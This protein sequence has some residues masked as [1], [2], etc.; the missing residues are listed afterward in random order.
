MRLRR[1]LDESLEQ[2][3]GVVRA[4]SSVVGDDILRVENAD[5]I[6]AE[7]VHEQKERYLAAYLGGA[8][9]SPTL[10]PCITRIIGRRCRIARLRRRASWYDDIEDGPPCRP[11]GDDHPSVWV[12]DGRAVAYVSQPYHL[13]H[14]SLADIVSFCRQWGLRADI[15]ASPSPH[16]PGQ[17]ITIVYQRADGS[18]GPASFRPRP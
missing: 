6:Y 3:R 14:E 13:H 4:L 12:R 17:T 7:A 10:H 16:F 8:K 18:L 15:V 5:R 2:H 11:P 9:R 1:F